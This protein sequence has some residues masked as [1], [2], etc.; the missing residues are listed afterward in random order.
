MNLLDSSGHGQACSVNL[1][2]MFE[3][4]VLET[5]LVLR[6]KVYLLQLFKRNLNSESCFMHP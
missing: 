1:F 4:G 3:N 2:V 5:E 6:Q